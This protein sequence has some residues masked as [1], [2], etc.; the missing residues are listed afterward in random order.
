MSTAVVLSE[1]DMSKWR[2]ANGQ[3]ARPSALPHGVDALEDEGVRLLWPGQL[4]GRL[5][6]VRRVFE[7]RSGLVLERPIRTM[8]KAC[9]ADAVIALLEQQAALPASLKARR[10]P[11]FS[12]TPLI[13]LSCWTAED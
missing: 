9:K 13:T 8:A 3:G 2:T 5:G 1:H 11:P 6:K 7:Q 12:S 4:Y 10:L